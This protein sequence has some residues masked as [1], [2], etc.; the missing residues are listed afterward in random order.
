MKVKAVGPAVSKTNVE[1][2]RAPASKS[3][4][5]GGGKAKGARVERG[6]TQSENSGAKTR[7]AV[8]PINPK[9]GR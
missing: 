4:P 6:R 5:V 7:L 8:G 2:G 3:T 1:R 9:A